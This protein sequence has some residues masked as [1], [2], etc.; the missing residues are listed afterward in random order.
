MNGN[1]ANES[2]AN[3]LKFRHTYFGKC[4]IQF[5]YFKRKFNIV[6]FKVLT[7][8]VAKYL[9]HENKTDDNPDEHTRYI[10]EK[11]SERFTTK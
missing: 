1:I 10:D 7:N 11:S 5:C 3:G 2:R 6:N 4:Q 9:P 8:V